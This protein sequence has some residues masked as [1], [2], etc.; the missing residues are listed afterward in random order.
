MR[1]PL[2]A[3]ALLA[4]A[5]P[6]M[7]ATDGVRGATSTATVQVS[8]TVEN[9]IADTVRISGLQD[10]DFGTIAVEDPFADPVSR[11]APVCLYHTSPSFTLTVTQVGGGIGTPF[12]LIGPAGDAIP[13]YIDVSNGPSAFGDAGF[14]ATRQV[15]NRAD[16]DCADGAFATLSVTR[17]PQET[18][19][20]GGLYSATI[21]IVMAAE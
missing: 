6:A 19:L 17:P 18:A 13:V 8:T 11:T 14:T 1:A 3:L 2:I 16:P 9:A 4:A 7:A 10:L 20:P 15:A 12:Q 21:S 5:A